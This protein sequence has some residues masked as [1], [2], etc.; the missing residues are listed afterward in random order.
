MKLNN[1]LA[2]ITFKTKIMRAT[3]ST[4]SYSKVVYWLS[5][6]TIRLRFEP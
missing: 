3:S 1:M 5:Y 4:Q 2:N 6:S